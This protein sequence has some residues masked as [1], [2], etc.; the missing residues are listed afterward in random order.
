MG[1]WDVLKK[2]LVNDGERHHTGLDEQTGKNVYEIASFDMNSASLTEKINYFLNNRSQGEQIQLADKL[3][4][5]G[6]FEA[7]IEMYQALIQKYPEERDRYE[8]G[9]GA[10]YLKLNEYDK[11]IEFYKTSRSHGMHPDITDKNIW[12]ACLKQYRT[13]NDIIY[14]ERYFD[15]T[16]NGKYAYLANDLLRNAGKDISNAFP[17]EPPVEIIEQNPISNQD[18]NPSEP[19]EI[20][21][22]EIIDSSNVE[23]TLNNEDVA[24][25]DK[26]SAENQFSLFGFG[27]NKD[28]NDNPEP[29]NTPE[30]SL[31]QVD[32]EEEIPEELLENEPVEEEPIVTNENIP[33]EEPPTMLRALDYH[34]DQFFANE[35][36]VVWTDKRNDNLR[37]DIYHIRPNEE[38]NYNLLLTFGMSRTPMNVPDGAEQFS[39]GELAIILPA[40]W[41]LSEEGLKDPNNYWPVLW[42]KNLAR[43][44]QQHNTWLCYGHSIPNQDPSKPIADTEFEGVVIMDSSTLPEDFQEMNLGEVSLYIYT[45]IPVYPEEMEYKVKNNIDHLRNAFIEAR[46]PDIV[47]TDRPTSVQENML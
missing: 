42:L 18:S 23:E 10:A 11:A 44:P 17:S 15:H 4:R 27:D 30:P 7:S 47:W 13:N 21:A 26:Q 2:K 20:I 38:R 43:I 28:S 16:E 33:V 3:L 9:I 19:V 6:P 8:N 35:D 31:E 22:T 1:I 34:I 32:D 40:D 5:E 29:S 24:K 36:V 25:K 37:I 46:I 41:D 14:I 45:V 12:D 39:Y